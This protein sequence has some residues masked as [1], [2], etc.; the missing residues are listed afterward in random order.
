MADDTRNDDAMG[1]GR[2]PGWRR[3]D[4]E[5]SSDEDGWCCRPA[6]GPTDDLMD[7]GAAERGEYNARS[8]VMSDWEA[9]AAKEELSLI[10][11]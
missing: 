1:R 7:S 2:G 4:E 8:S 11:I 5:E 3:F 9:R 6:N 10:H